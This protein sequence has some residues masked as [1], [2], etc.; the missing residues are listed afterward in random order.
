M[1]LVLSLTVFPHCK[2]TNSLV[3]R[4]WL[5]I[6][7][8]QT[9]IPTE[10]F[11]YT[12]LGLALQKSYQICINLSSAISLYLKAE[13]SHKI[14]RRNDNQHVFQNKQSKMLSFLKIIRKEFEQK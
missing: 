9:G 2:E 1:A 7:R 10:L 6:L 4:Q 14:Q 12:Y 8:Y 5:A 3:K 13:V 11:A